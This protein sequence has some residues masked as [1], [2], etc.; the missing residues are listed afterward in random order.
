MNGP[1]EVWET[2]RREAVRVGP[3]PAVLDGPGGRRAT[4]W[5]IVHVLWAACEVGDEEVAAAIGDLLPRYRRGPA[6]AA[7]PRGDRYY[8]D[9]AWLGLA[10]LRAAEVR[11]DPSWRSLGEELAAYV[12]TG[13]HPLGGIRWREGDESRNTCSTASSAWLVL[14]AGAS[15][16]EVDAA[17]WLDWIDERVRREDGLIGDRVE[18]GRLRRRAWTYNQGATIAATRLLGRDPTRLIE[19]AFTHW[20]PAHL[21]TEPPAF[22]ALL[23]RALLTDPDPAVQIDT[24]QWLDPY[25]ARLSIEARHPGTGWYTQGG[26]G[27]Y[28]GKPTIDQA[29]VV[30]LLALRSLSSRTG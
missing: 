2:L 11:D 29:A 9:N 3:R 18:R 5:A 23:A 16:A 15:G 4:L 13:E 17:R 28:D 12:A 21:W 24:Q 8:D 14:A 10:C 30:Q 26:V 7:T 19:A 22:V 27:S 1:A 25:L 20:T 6:F